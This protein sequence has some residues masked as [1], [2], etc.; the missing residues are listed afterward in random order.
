MTVYQVQDN[1]TIAH[2]FEGW[3]ETMI[4]SYLQG[5]MG[6]AYTTNLD[7]PKNAMI[8]VGDLCFFAGMVDESLLYFVKDFISIL[9]PKDK[10]WEKK[11]EEVLPMA[12]KRKRY[13]TK[14]DNTTFNKQHLKEIVSKLSAEY[15][16]QSIDMEI[17]Q[18]LKK[19]PWAGDLY[20]NFKDYT[21]FMNNGMG[22]VV[23]HQ[24][25]VVTRA[26]SYT[27]YKNGIE[28]QIDTVKEYQRKGLGLICAAKLILECMD[29][30]IYPSWDAHNLG[31]LALS[32]K[33]GY[34]F[35]K[36][37]VAYEIG[38]EEMT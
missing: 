5:Y 19:E 12:K 23:L 26:S 10:C 17:Y 29:R 11:I 4:Y 27:V 28:I 35:D 1:K 8:K 38:M 34:Q 21:D 6:E 33:L 13:A 31:S 32:K 14:K 2:L 25:K 18:Q 15:T 7:E 24:G 16:I 9:V 36:E 20:T 22:V 37:Y 30:N 3:E